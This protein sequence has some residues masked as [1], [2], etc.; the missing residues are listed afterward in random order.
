[1]DE[2]RLIS[3]GRKSPVARLILGHFASR[4]RNSTQ[5]T[6][7]GLRA[8]LL[9]E[10][11]EVSRND[12]VS[13]FKELAEAGCGTFVVGRKG[14]PT[15]FEWV[16]ALSRAGSVAVAKATTANDQI[17]EPEQSNSRM[18]L[19]HQYILR[20][21]FTVKLSL[22]LDLSETEASRLADF[23]RTIPFG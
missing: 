21:D 9:R 17:A 6:V 12:V 13:T 14:H 20:Q 4:Q 16:V 23:I 5:T 22:P 15:R 19:D 7:D 3:L 10:G 2:T 1:M 11:R 8:A 18:T